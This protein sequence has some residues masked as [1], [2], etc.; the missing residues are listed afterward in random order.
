MQRNRDQRPA[1]EQVLNGSA[2]ENALV[3]MALSAGVDVL[4]L[5]ARHARV[6]IDYRAENHLYMSTLHELAPGKRLLAVKGSPNEVLALC[7]YTLHGGVMEVLS[8]ERRQSIKDDNE[9][10]SGEALRVLGIAYAEVDAETSVPESG[11]VWVGLV[12]M[13][14]P[15]RAGVR[16]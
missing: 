8:D 6:R 14:D 1:G 10:M 13:A 11:L 9:R 7:G 3:H 15:V 5:R 4:G 12:G 2:T 16:S